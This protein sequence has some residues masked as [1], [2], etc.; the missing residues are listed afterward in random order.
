VY[1]NCPPDL[2]AKAMAAVVKAMAVA[3][4]APAALLRG[5]QAAM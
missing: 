3:I 4:A 1:S 2:I 5:L